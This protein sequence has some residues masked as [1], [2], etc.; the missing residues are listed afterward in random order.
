[1]LRKIA[2]GSRR[3]S[4]KNR[5]NKNSFRFLQGID[6]NLNT[7]HQAK[8]KKLNNPRKEA[9]LEE[10]LTKDSELS[11]NLPETTDFRI[12]DADHYPVMYRDV[13]D[14]IETWYQEKKSKTDLSLPFTL[15][16][17]GVGTAGHTRRLLNKYP[18]LHVYS[19]P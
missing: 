3:F 11:T 8:P 18:G 1:M 6:I 14:E 7:A 5:L 4:Q 15:V 2:L 9:H 17:C 12:E 13:E 10:G 19:N 16:D